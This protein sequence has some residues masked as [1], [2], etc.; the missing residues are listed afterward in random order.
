[1]RNA[2]VDLNTQ[3][4]KNRIPNGAL[5]VNATGCSANFG[6][7]GAGTS[8]RV[9]DNTAPNGRSFFR[10]TWS[11]AST[12]ISKGITFAG[13]PKIEA[14]QVYTLSI[15]ARTNRAQ[16]INAQ[17]Q[18]I[19]ASS[20]GVRQV[21]GTPTTMVPGQ[22]TR[23][24]LTFTAQATEVTAEIRL[25]AITPGTVWQV[26]DVLDATMAMLSDG[27]TL[28]DYCDGYT[29]GWRFIDTAGL[30]ESVGYPYTLEAIMGKPAVAHD[31]IKSTNIAPPT[32]F[33]ARTL[34]LVWDITGSA[35]NY[36]A[37]ILAGSTSTSSGS[38]RLQTAVA[39]ATSVG[40]R[41]DIFNGTANSNV[42]GAPTGRSNGRH[43]TM[44]QIAEGITPGG[45]LLHD[46]GVL[47]QGAVNLTAGD[48][49]P[50][51]LFQT[52]GAVGNNN[53]V[54]GMQYFAFHSEAQARA[55]TKWLSNRYGVPI[56]A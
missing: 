45:K 50:G 16:T 48:G 28:Y 14:G 41:I 34:Y 32:A 7:G 2:V 38:I 49:I 46:N 3:P 36:K 15:W 53:P 24:Y 47:T 23:L 42:G 6:T 30:S 26:G 13:N 17:L 8:G 33:S 52:D 39:G 25:Y 44:L 18:T 31:G 12:E 51:S 21:T 29:P 1:M 11:T 20:V 19:N 5:A 4:I 54:F 22:W 43:I 37:V 56:A 40:A 10:M 9:S 27:P 35:D 55:I